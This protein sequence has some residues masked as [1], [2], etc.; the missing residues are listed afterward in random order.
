MAK[1]YREHV[2]GEKPVEG[3]VWLDS[4]RPASNNAASPIN[5]RPEGSRTG[6]RG[7]VFQSSLVRS[8]TKAVPIGNGLC[9]SAASQ[10]FERPGAVLNESNFKLSPHTSKLDA[11][12]GCPAW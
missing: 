9:A 2:L 1:L 8:T 12:S 4:I 10:G 7:L 5:R 6:G 3:L 11:H